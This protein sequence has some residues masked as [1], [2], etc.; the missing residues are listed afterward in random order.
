MHLK[1]CLLNSQKSPGLSWDHWE[2]ALH[3]S[4][5]VDN[6]ERGQATGLLGQRDEGS[7]TQLPEPRDEPVE[8]AVT[9]RTLPCCL[10]GGHRGTGSVCQPLAVLQSRAAPQSHSHW[11]SGCCGAAEGLDATVEIN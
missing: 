4:T 9:P 5:Q 2:H 1:N 10:A 6:M 11:C 3:S 7:S 8:G